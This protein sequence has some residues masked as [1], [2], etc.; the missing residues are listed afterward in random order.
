MVNRY[1]N[2]IEEKLKNIKEVKINN[3]NYTDSRQDN[4]TKNKVEDN[5]D[6]NIPTFLKEVEK[7]EAIS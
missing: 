7:G 4:S 3:K 6:N 1:F 5:I 2:R